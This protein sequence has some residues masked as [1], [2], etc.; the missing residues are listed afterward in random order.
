MADD[1]N[2]PLGRGAD[3]PRRRPARVRGSVVG[4]ALA[5]LGGGCLA[6]LFVRGDFGDGAPSAIARIEVVEPPKAEPSPSEPPQPPSA[7]RNP[8]AAAEIEQNSGVKVTRIG[9]G[10]APGALVIKLED[11][12][13]RLSPAPDRRLVENGRQGT[14]PRIGAD[15]AKPMDVYARPP[16]ISAKLPANAPRI[17]LV[18]GGVGLNAQLSD[19]AIDELPEATTL[20]LAPYGAGVEA[21]AARARERGHEILLQAPMEPFD[22]PRENP[23]PH[24]LLTHGSA[25]EDLHWQMSRFPGYVGVVNFLGARFTADEAALKPA[26]ADI[27]GRGLLFLDDGASPQSLVAK[28]A[29]GLSLA[30]ARA[31]VSIEAGASPEAIDAA[32]ARLEAQARRNGSAIVVAPALPA[33]IGKLSRFARDL[34]RRGVALAPLSAIVA[35][36]DAIEARAGRKSK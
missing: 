31:D 33:A 5:L 12:G 25:I 23:G 9:G 13:P 36:T 10:E 11:A 17:A 8:G 35:R 34:E 22:Y 28:L 21:T 20:A 3:V 4:L 30:A 2:D 27:A 16:S 15:G 7:E 24:T 14:L 18:V 6:V 19:R 29:P 26:L 32:L 1:L